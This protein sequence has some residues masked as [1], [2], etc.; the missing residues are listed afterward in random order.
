MSTVPTQNNEVSSMLATAT[1]HHQAG[2]L[3]EAEAMYKEILKKFPDQPDALQF[4]GLLAHNKNDN[5]SA[6]ELIRKAISINPFSADYYINLGAIFKQLG[7]LREAL[8]CYQTALQ[9]QPESAEA[10]NNLG[11]VFKEQGRIPQAKEAF[12]K[13]ISIKP[14]FSHK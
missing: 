14:K 7:R 12:D 10:Y 6:I 13:A 1:R 11:N 5:Q 2:R 3:A 9:L 8:E 4:L